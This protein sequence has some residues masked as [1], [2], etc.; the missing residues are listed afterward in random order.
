M[1]CLCDAV[2]FAFFFFKQ[3]TAYEMRISDWS[4]DVCSSDLL[5]LSGGIGWDSETT[6]E[7]G[8]TYYGSDTDWTGFDD[9]TRDIPKSLAAALASGRPILEGADFSAGDLEAIAMDLVNAPTTLLQQNTHIPVNWSA[10][11][12][13]GPTISV[14][15]GEVGIIPTAGISNKWRSE[16]RSVGK[17]GGGTD[18]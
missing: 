8:Y 5:T 7:L 6:N 11:L 13:G 4:S 3:K 12:T 2:F 1:W 10:G 16:E 17:E 14:G 18:R 15:D 9:G